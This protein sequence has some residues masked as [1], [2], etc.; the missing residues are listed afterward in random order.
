[1]TELTDAEKAKTNKNIYPGFR[2][3]FVAYFSQY[4]DNTSIHCVRYL[5]Q[6][7]R[8]LLERLWWFLVIATSLCLCIML[9]VSTYQKWVMSPVIVSFARSSTPVWKIPFPAITVCPETKTKQRVYNFTNEYHRF[10]EHPENMT[11]EEIQMFNQVSLVC[12]NRVHEKG[13]KTI[14][15]DFIDAFTKVAPSFTDVLWQCKWLNENRTCSDLFTPVLTEEGICFTFNMLDREELFTDDV[16]HGGNFSQHGIK[17]E[18]WS[19][20]HGYGDDLGLDTFP[21]RAVASGQKACLSLLMNLYEPD[22]DYLCKGAVQGFKILLH[23]PTE[24]PR[25]SQQYFRA[26]LNQEV[27]VA[28]KPDMIT[29]SDGLRTYNVDSRH[30]YFANEKLLKFYQIYTQK[31]CEVEC[32]TNITLELCNCVA[33]YMPRVEGTKICG[34]GSIAC[35][36]Q[37]Q[38]EMFTREVT[39]GL[40]KNQQTSESCK[41]WPSCS[42]LTYNAESSQA[43]FNWPKVFEG[44]K[45]NFSEFPGVAMTRVYFYFKEQQFITSQRNELY[46]FS[47]FLASCG[48]LLGLFIGF[49]SLSII[50]ILYFVSLRVLTNIKRYGS[51][52]WSGSVD[53]LEDDAYQHKSD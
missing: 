44:F 37:A 17:T 51:H 41:C 14:A 42:S 8:S 29:T 20:E 1:M 12:N 45:V 7:K 35:I 22:L 3:N 24:T 27:V 5:G 48:G 30:C 52:F 11:E 28:I 50:E 53:L 31:N 43:D 4:S 16:F 2:K 9:I 46:G 47:D 18:N 49:S 38:A 32:L 15:S 39:V 33:F 6:Y 36:K 40:D 13:D 34:P 26:P 25:V 10:N 19:L 21:R 23:S